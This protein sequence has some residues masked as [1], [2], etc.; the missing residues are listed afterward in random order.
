[1][2][3]RQITIDN[4]IIFFIAYNIAVSLSNDMYLTS[5]PLLV[6]FFNT[7]TQMIQLTLTVWF[8]GLVLLQLFMGPLCHKFGRKKL[9]IYG[10]GLFVAATMICM[11]SKS[12]FI[13][14]GGRFLQGIGVCSASVATIMCIREIYTHQQSIKLFALLGVFGALVPVFAPLIGSYVQSLLSWQ[15]IFVIILLLAIVP[16]FFLQRFVPESCNAKDNQQLN[17]NLLVESYREILRNNFFIRNVLSY[18]ILFGSLVAYVTFIPFLVIDYFHKSPTILGCLQIVIFGAYMLGSLC[19][20]Y[21]KNHYLTSIMKVGYLFVFIS[22]AISFICILTRLENLTLFSIKFFVY[23]FGAGILMS[24]MTAN[25]LNCVNQKHVGYAS[26][27]YGFLSMFISMCSSFL[28]SLTTSL[29][30]FDF[31]LL[32]FI[33]ILLILQFRKRTLYAK[34]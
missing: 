7:S 10:G 25:S 29:I 14:L 32:I 17:F 23:S 26:S 24:P 28:V 21:V 31:L 8:A 27:L 4:L 5:M 1:M 9:L 33:F 11:C 19:V 12:I 34:A 18:G 20:S 30:H 6:N 22:M 13:F 16:L 2:M 3:K 15:S